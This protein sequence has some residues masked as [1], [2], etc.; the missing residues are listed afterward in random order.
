MLVSPVALAAAAPAVAAE[1]MV[2]EDGAAPVCDMPQHITRLDYPLTRM[3][4]AIVSNEDIV[5]VAF[6]S[7]STTGAGASRPE[8]NYPSQLQEQLRRLFPD[9]NIIVHNKG[10]NGE[11]VPEMAKRVQ[12]VIDLKPHLVLWQLGANGVLKD[13]PFASYGR[14]IPAIIHQIK[15]ATDAD[16]VLVDPQYAPKVVSQPYAKITLLMIAETAVRQKVG[17]FRR[18]D[19]MKHWMTDNK[20]GFDRFI[21]DGVHLNDWGYA[22]WAQ[23]F[24]DA[25][26]EAARR[27]LAHPAAI[28]RPLGKRM[29]PKG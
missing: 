4:R 13:Q 16:V 26:A 23:N 27:P 1:P 11:E 17:L 5:I 14:L 8:A 28:A 18:F 15:Q 21:A 7:S 29:R 20:I 6:G 9:H 12:D 2:V 3:A 10:V 25:I 24:G 22:C 19:L